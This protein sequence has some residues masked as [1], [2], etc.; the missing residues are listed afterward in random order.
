MAEPTAD[1]LAPG[2][3]ELEES[4]KDHDKEKKRSVE[5]LIIFFNELI[6]CSLA[7]PKSSQVKNF[8]FLP[9]LTHACIHRKKSNSLLRSSV[10]VY[11][12]KR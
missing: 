12:F 6:S 4:S 1:T 10:S 11:H 5:I 3:I 9:S 2:Q 8:S 7:F